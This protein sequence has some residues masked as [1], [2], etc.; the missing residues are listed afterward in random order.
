MARP[1]LSQGKRLNRGPRPMAEAVPA[2]SVVVA[3]L[4]ALLPIISATG[5]WPNWGVLMLVAWRMLRADAWPAWWAAPL[6]FFNDLVTGDPIGLSIASWSAIMIVMDFVDRRTQWR[7]YWIEWA[8]AC[9]LIAGCELAQWWAATASGAPVAFN[10]STGPSIISSILCFP[11]AARLVAL[12]D[13]WRLR[14]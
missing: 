11:L 14:P 12:I 9:L 8:A 5:W 10:Q 2:L 6:G 13:R 4:F 1:T 3:S 7:D